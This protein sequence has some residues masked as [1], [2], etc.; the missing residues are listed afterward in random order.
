MMTPGRYGFF[1]ISVTQHEFSF[2]DPV[3]D[4][5]GDSSDGLEE[6]LIKGGW[7]LVNCH[8]WITLGELRDSG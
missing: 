7:S 1:V 3:L 2:V 4:S 6:T 8:A 5:S